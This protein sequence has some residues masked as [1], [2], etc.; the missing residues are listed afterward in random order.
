MSFKDYI[1]DAQFAMLD[2]LLVC[3]ENGKA[4]WNDELRVRFEFYGYVDLLPV[5]DKMKIGGDMSSYPDYFTEALIVIKKDCIIYEFHDGETG[6]AFRV[7]E[8]LYTF[9]EWFVG[10]RVSTLYTILNSSDIANLNILVY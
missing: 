8:A 4:A 5:L 9:K 1:V 3:M 6:R 2:A 10:G 7:Y